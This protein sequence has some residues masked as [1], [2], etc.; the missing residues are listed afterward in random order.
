MK[1]FVFLVVL[2]IIGYVCYVTWTGMAATG[3]GAKLD[4][5]QQTLQDVDK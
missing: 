4:K 3:I 2:G 5:N 1:A